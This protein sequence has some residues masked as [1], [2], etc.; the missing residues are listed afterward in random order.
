VAK[1]KA[2]GE[3]FKST[4]NYQGRVLMRPAC[5]LYAAKRNARAVIADTSFKTPSY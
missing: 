4:D 1:V 3:E 2:R 5:L